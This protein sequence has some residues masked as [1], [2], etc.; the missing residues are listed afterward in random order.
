MPIICHSSFL[1]FG[2]LTLMVSTLSYTGWI[3]FWVIQYPRYSICSTKNLDLDALTLIPAVESLASTI[4][5]HRSDHVPN[6][7]YWKWVTLRQWTEPSEIRNN[8]YSSIL[9]GKFIFHNILGGISFE[10]YVATSTGISQCSKHMFL[11]I[12][13]EGHH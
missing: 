11:M 3:P 13:L 1:V 7:W 12:D 4:S 6:L 9:L 2:A 5:N 10:N 8:A